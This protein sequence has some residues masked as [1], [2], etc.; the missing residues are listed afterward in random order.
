MMVAEKCSLAKGAVP[1]LSKGEKKRVQNVVPME[2]Q[3]TP[4]N[5]LQPF[6]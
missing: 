5:A 6:A 4:P 2:N 1:P 3:L